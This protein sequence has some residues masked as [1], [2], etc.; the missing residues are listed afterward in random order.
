MIPAFSLE[1]TQ[2]ILFLLNNLVENGDIPSI[3]V[4]V[5][6]PLAIRVTEIYKRASQYMSTEVQT[7]IREGDDVFHFPKLKLARESKESKAINEVPNPK[8]IIAGSG[9]STGGR[10]TH[11]EKHNLPDPKSTLLLVGYQGV[12]TLGREIEEGA[13]RV[14]IHG[15][16]IPVRAHVEKIEGFS[17]HKDRD[18][19]LSFVDQTSDSLKKVFVVMGEP[20]SA[21]ALVQ[22]INDYLGVSAL[23]PKQGQTY[24]LK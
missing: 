2:E 23:Y 3:P 20:K 22:R 9:M 13:R 1:R 19:L 12:G 15:D 5:D 17:S 24:E 10:I 4:Y 6:S 21:L 16:M 11:H 8:I 18:H 14:E 7:H